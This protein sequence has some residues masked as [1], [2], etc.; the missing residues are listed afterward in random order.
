MLPEDAIGRAKARI[1]VDHISKKVIPAFYTFLQA[2]E[3][4]EQDEG[5]EKLLQGLEKL[6]KAMAPSTEGPYFF[7]S[8]FTTVDIALVPWVLRFAT[9]MKKY[10]NFELPTEGGENNVWSRFKTWEDAAVN[11][12]S[13]KNTSS[14]DEKYFHVY[15]RYAENTTQSEV[16]KATRAGKA[17]P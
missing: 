2:Q 10:R 15:K 12:Q 5:R 7:G 3:K 9:V 8:Q 14:D 17:L 13:V 4:K 11:R 6:V 1:W 16:A